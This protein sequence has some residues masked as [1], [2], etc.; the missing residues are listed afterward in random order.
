MIGVQ[1]A[2]LF[3][4][5]IADGPK[6]KCLSLDGIKAYS[7]FHHEQNKYLFACLNPL[8]EISVEHFMWFF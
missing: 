2:C 7:I 3:V 6:I 4:S 1:N 8:K 5:K